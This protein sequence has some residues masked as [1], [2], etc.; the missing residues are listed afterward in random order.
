MWTATGESCDYTI[1]NYSILSPH[2]FITEIMLAL[3]FM[4]K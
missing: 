3:H 2:H 1:S 4:K